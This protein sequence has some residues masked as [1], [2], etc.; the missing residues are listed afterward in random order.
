MTIRIWI[1]AREHAA[2]MMMGWSFGSHWVLP[3]EAF[4]VSEF[5]ARR[6]ALRLGDG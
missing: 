1:S 4:E 3:G 2:G 6:W 5:T